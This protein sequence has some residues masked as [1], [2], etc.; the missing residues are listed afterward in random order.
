M[1]RTGNMSTCMTASIAE[2]TIISWRPRVPTP[3]PPI[4]ARAQPRYTKHPQQLSLFK[5]LSSSRH[6]TGTLRAS[7]TAVGRAE[8]RLN[9]NMLVV[10]KPPSG[11]QHHQQLYLYRISSRSSAP[12]GHFNDTIV[13]VAPSTVA[14][15]PH[16]TLLLPP[17]PVSRSFLPLS[18]RCWT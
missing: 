12:G 17:L 9:A 15:L 6:G 4:E 8:H 16:G 1:R 13:P 5:T 3:R 11:Y 7:S 18:P 10:S 2:Y 14:W